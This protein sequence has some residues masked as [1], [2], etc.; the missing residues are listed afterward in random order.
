MAQTV[1]VDDALVTDEF[2]VGLDALGRVRISPTDVSQFIRLEQCER[3]LRLQ[4]HQRSAGLRFMDDF[5]VHPQAIP[6]LLTRSGEQFEDR[7]E[8]VVAERFAT[9]HLGER[10]DIPGSRPTDNDRVVALA[11]DLPAG[12]TLVI[13]QPRLLVGLG[14]WDVRG[15]IDVLRLARDAS[16]ALQILIADVK[17]STSAKVEHRLQVAFYSEMVAALL[18]GAGIGVERID[19]GILYRGPSDDAPPATASD[20]DRLDR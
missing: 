7:V 5:G 6:P 11:R 15:D 18:A 14:I 12:E 4:L 10:I 19:L 13:F 2:S 3:Y 16:G 20:R 9:I 17:S 8:R 1:S